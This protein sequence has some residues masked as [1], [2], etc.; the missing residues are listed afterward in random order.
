VGVDSGYDTLVVHQ[1]LRLS[2]H[3]RRADLWRLLLSLGKGGSELTRA[4]RL[5]AGVAQ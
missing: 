4:E 1:V 2:L 3:L 5:E